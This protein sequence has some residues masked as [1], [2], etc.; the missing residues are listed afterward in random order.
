MIFIISDDILYLFPSSPTKKISAYI[1]KGQENNSGHEETG[2][3]NRKPDKVKGSGEEK[4][5]RNGY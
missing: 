2:D 5:M 4:D 1:L 3:G